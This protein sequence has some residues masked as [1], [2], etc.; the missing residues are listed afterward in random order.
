MGFA[1]F[2]IF[3]ALVAFLVWQFVETKNAVATL[4]VRSPHD[5]TRT[6]QIV[7]TAFGGARSI[8]WTDVSGPGA[9]N[10]RRRGKDGGITMSID[11]EA[12]EAGGTRVDMWASQTNVYLLMFV[13]F[14]GVVNRRK[15]AIAR[16]LSA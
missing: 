11:L 1:L 14:A 3:A 16:L 4:S 6:A 15:R 5:P 2:L 9:I 8:L 13:N 10:K 12:M 7:D